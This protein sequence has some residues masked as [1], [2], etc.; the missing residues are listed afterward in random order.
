MAT[1]ELPR[2]CRDCGEPHSSGRSRC[3]NCR[4]KIHLDYKKRVEMG[5]CVRCSKPASAGAFC[6]SHWIRN[7]GSAHGLANKNGVLLL[8]RIWEEQRGVCAVTGQTLI[9]GHNASLDHI[10][11]VSKS[12][13]NER[14]NLRWVLLSINRAKSDMT[15][16]EFVSMCR[17]VVQA[18]SLTPV[19]KST[20]PLSVARSN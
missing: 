8:S 20:E 3:F 5:Q 15:H 12:G 4:E 7:I 13:T 17:S 11:P 6:F 9:P 1:A 16:D 19:I 10:V 2:S 18:E 14:T